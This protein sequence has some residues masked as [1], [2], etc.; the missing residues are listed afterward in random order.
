MLYIHV[1]HIHLLVWFPF[2]R[3]SAQREKDVLWIQ[4]GGGFETAL[5][6]FPQSPN[7][8]AGTNAT[9]SPHQQFSS[10]CKIHAND[11]CGHVAHM[12][13]S[14]QTWPFCRARSLC[15]LYKPLC[16]W[17]QTNP[18]IPFK[19]G[20]GMEGHRPL[21]FGMGSLYLFHER[22]MS[23]QSF[24]LEPSHHTESQKRHTDNSPHSV[25]NGGTQRQ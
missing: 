14:K 22:E 13:R 8:C 3:S 2:R 9:P 12:L 23:L 25:F 7:T 20:S 1:P 19:H 18:Q 21:G 4:T 24:V 16:V 15:C 17:E 6:L 10:Q 11:I 5:H